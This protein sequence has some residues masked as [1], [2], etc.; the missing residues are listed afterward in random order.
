M[1][2]KRQN[3]TYLFC[4][5]NA[6]YAASLESRKVYLAIPDQAATARGFVRIIDESGED[7][8]YPANRFVPVELPIAARRT[9]AK[10]S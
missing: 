3:P 4:L 5:K 8:L 10:A 9:L 7:Y 1:A 6:G 2:T